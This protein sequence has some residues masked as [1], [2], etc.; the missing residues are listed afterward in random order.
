MGKNGRK[1]LIKR[2]K[3]RERGE[4]GESRERKGELAKE[5]DMRRYGKKQVRWSGKRGGGRST[6]K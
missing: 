5:R 6:D 3:E 2:N 4:E 1:R